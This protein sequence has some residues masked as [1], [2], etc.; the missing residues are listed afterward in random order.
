MKSDSQCETK[1]KQRGDETHFRE[2]AL[3][4]LPDNLASLGAGHHPEHLIGLSRLVKGSVKLLRA[5]LYRIS[6]DYKELDGGLHASQYR[7]SAPRRSRR[8]TVF[9]LAKTSPVVGQR[10]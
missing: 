4:N 7:L 3:P 6:A 5:S 2:Q 1:W 10:D 8:L 9:T